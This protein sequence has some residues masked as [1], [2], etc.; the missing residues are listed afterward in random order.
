MEEEDGFINESGLDFKDIS[1][2]TFRDYVFPNGKKLKIKDPVYLHV[3]KSGGHRLFDGAGFSWYI[4][5]Q[6]SWY[7]KWF[8]PYGKP[9]FSM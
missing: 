3:S 7:I 6:Q 5:L 2:E 1:D 4:Q 9:N 8:V